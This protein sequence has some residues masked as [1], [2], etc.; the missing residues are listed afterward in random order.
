M[1]VKIQEMNADTLYY[2]ILRPHSGFASCP[3]DVFYSRMILFRIM[4]CV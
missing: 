4:C 3:N 1:T 2:V